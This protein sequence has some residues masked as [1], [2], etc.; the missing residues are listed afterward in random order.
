MRPPRRLCASLSLLTVTGLTVSACAGPEQRSAWFGGYVNATAYPYYEFGMHGP[1]LGRTV[2]GFVV[3]DPES[4]CSPSWGGYFDLDQ[5]ATELSMDQQVAAVQDSGGEVVV[6]FGGEAGA[7]LATACTDP[8]QLYEAYSSVLERYDVT[9]VDFDVEMDDLTDADAAAR[10]GEAVARLQEENTDLEVWV[11]LPGSPP[12]LDEDS[13]T[14]VQQ[15]LEAGVDLAGVNVMTM[16]YS[17]SKPAEQSMA[18]ASEDTARAVHAQLQEIYAQQGEELTEDELWSRIGLTPMI[19][20]NDVAG[21][22]LDLDGAAELNRFAQEQGIGRMSYWSA[23]RDRSCA[24]EDGDPEV[25]NDFCSGVEQDDDA[26]A[27]VL[28]EGFD[29]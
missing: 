10:R 4:D 15:M 19:G 8:T 29:G 1:E 5:A 16:N 14:V 11:T 23:N 20:Q 18:A 13:Q 21:E 28:R 12:G 24:P 25:A 27:A 6:S 26:F 9:T 17:E 2:L 22:V 3:A 7:E